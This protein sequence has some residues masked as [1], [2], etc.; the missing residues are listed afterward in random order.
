[1]V[2]ELTF[3]AETFL[4]LPINERVQLCRQLAQRAQA[5][6]DAADPKFRESYL[7]IAKNWLKLAAEME[8]VGPME[9]AK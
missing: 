1:M 4:A 7:D 8:G 3:D 9:H 2:S 6:A 5:L